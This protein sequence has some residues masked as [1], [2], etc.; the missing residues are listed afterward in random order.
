MSY[1][2]FWS[3]YEQG[4]KSFHFS[5]K[6]HS[7]NIETF[8]KVDD[9]TVMVAESEWTIPTDGGEGM[10]LEFNYA[11]IPQEAFE[12]AFLTASG[13][14]I[15]ARMTNMLSENLNTY[16]SKTVVSTISRDEVLVNFTN[17][18]PEVER[19]SLVTLSADSKQ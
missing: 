3:K 18:L 16:S 5:M 15:A 10:W 1:K 17:T 9:D 14:P 7:G 8:V 11:R 12:R 19:L 13:F 4:V 2:E 6:T